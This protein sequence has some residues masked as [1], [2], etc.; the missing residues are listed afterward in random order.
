MGIG[1][2]LLVGVA[3]GSGHTRSATEAALLFGWGL[4]AARDEGPPA[5]Q[6]TGG[7]AGGAVLLQVVDAVG[8]GTLPPSALEEDEV[9]LLQ[10]GHKGN[11]LSLAIPIT[12]VLL[13]LLVAGVAAYVELSPA[14]AED[15]TPAPAP[16]PPQPLTVETEATPLVPTS[17]R[18]ASS[19]GDRTPK[20]A[21]S[22]GRRLG[23]KNLCPELVVPQKK[24]CQLFLLVQGGGYTVVDS[25]ENAV[26]KVAVKPDPPI[27][28]LHST[29]GEALC[30]VTLSGDPTSLF[31][32]LDA[33][34][35]PWG[36]VRRGGVAHGREVLQVMSRHYH[37]GKQPFWEVWVKD[38]G[39]GRWMTRHC[40]LDAVVAEADGLDPRYAAGLHLRHQADASIMISLI[41]AFRCLVS[42]PPV[43]Q[44]L[45]IERDVAEGTGEGG[46]AGVAS[47]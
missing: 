25:W 14:A 38:G 13:M 39:R 23:Y 34:G 12:A 6:G 40:P 44:P 42:S 21:I 9:A 24:Q 7:S 32:F 37:D 18:E 31:T 41:V 11:R 2:L 4:E 8:P 35:R 16:P 1:I 47:F 46:D 36:F 10:E 29:A 20:S 3:G 43:V 15:K 19:P 28:E 26:L 22:T 30:T 5:V 45:L 33:S 27:V 17:T